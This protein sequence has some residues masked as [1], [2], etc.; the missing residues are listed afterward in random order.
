M[1][2]A[3]ALVWTQALAELAHT[4]P[5]GGRCGGADAN[6]KD[7]MSLS[8]LFYYFF[9]ETLYAYWGNRPACRPVRSPAS[10]VRTDRCGTDASGGALV[11]F[12]IT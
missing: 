2:K 7:K 10:H 6:G 12:N 4:R 9:G 3:A 1:R 5:R 8:F 11:I